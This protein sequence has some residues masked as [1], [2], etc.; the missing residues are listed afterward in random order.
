MTKKMLAV[1][2]LLTLMNGL[3]LTIQ[4]AKPLQATTITGKPLFTIV[5]YD[6]TASCPT[7]STLAFSDATSGAS[8]STI[9]SYPT[10][11]VTDAVFSTHPLH[12]K[13]CSQ[14]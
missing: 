2:T 4:I 3:M 1:L 8:V 14:N 12:Y 10:S 9:D 5:G 11:L 7:G 6:S 13:V